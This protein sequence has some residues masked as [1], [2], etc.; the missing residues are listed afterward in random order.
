MKWDD[1]GPSKDL[2]DGR[3]ESSGG[4]GGFRDRK[5]VV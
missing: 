3:G 1:N 5:S 2:E 4:G